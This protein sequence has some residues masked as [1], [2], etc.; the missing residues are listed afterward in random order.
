MLPNL[1]SYLID[2]SANSQLIGIL[3]NAIVIPFPQ[4]RDDSFQIKLG[5]YQLLAGQSP[6]SRRW[7]L[8]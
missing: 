6:R 4:E 5:H 7:P 2:L 1:G 8:F 3:H